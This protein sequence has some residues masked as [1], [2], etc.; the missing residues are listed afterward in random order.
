MVMVL[1]VPASEAELHLVPN[2]RLLPRSWLAA[3]M[4]AVCLCAQYS[5]TE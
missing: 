4:A 2:Y 3:H 1:E 5:I